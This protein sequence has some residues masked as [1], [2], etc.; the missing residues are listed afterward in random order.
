MLEITG[1]L[2]Q[3]LSPC[4]HPLLGLPHRAAEQNCPCVL[5]T[6][7]GLQGPGRHCGASRL[8]LPL[9]PTSSSLPSST[10]PLF[11][12]PSSLPPS[13][14]QDPQLQRPPVHPSSGLP[15]PALPAPTVSLPALH[16]SREI[17]PTEGPAT[18]PVGSKVPTSGA[19]AGPTMSKGGRPVR[20]YSSL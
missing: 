9:S 3:S 16:S 13:L 11:L 15:G 14:P 5:S 2:G 10:S 12:P 20:S 7:L 6:S 19:P 1:L 8:I 18:H 17:C 4:S